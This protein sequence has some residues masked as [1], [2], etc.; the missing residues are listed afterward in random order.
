MIPGAY[1]DRFESSE[2]RGGG[3]FGVDRCGSPGRIASIGVLGT[4]GA[5]EKPY[6][7]GSRTAVGFSGSSCLG[8]DGRACR[9]RGDA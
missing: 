4:L 6:C 3:I 7:R 1:V 9:G 5:L 2:G 8:G